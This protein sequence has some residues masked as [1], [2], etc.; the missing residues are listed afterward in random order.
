MTHFVR[1]IRMQDAGE[2]AELL[3]YAWFPPR[4]EAGWKWLCRSPAS[5]ATRAVPVGFVAEDRDGRVG[6]VFGL[7]AQDYVS[8]EGPLSGGTGHTLIVHPRLRGA[9]RPLIDAV[10]DQQALFAV[11]VLHANDLAA[12]IYRRHGMAPFP[13]GRD[14]M[15]VV[16]VTDPLALMAER[17]T[18]ASKVRLG[19]DGRPTREW[20]LR[21]RVFNTA[22]ERLDPGVSVLSPAELDRRIDAFDEALAGED[23][24]SARRDAAALHWRFSNPDR[25]RDPILLA[26]MDGE[27]IGGLLLAE[28]T[29]VTQL[30][31]PTLEIIDLVALAQCADH[32][33]PALVRSLVHNAARLGC[34]RVRLPVVSEELEARLVGVPGMHRRTG[35][36]HGFIWARPRTD[37]LINEWRLTP[38]DGEFGL[39]FRPPPRSMRSTRGLSTQAWAS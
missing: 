11:T 12:P 4:S 17:A 28:I 23:R 14:R 36:D 6:G 9:S 18:R 13:M 16:W 3:D 29:K 2:I 8:R 15:S 33:I 24:L 34:A 35:H 5:V 31:A 1:P 19:R 37:A 21:D 20:F 22:L 30:D 32:A 39:C 25:T 26:W 7:F 38:Y 10:L 27:D